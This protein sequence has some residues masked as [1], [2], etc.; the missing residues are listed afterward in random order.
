VMFPPALIRIRVVSPGEK[1]IALWL[2]IFLLWIP[3]LVV[4]VAATPLVLVLVLV[5]VLMPR[6]RRFLRQCFDVFRLLC[7]SRGTR[8]E[9]DDNEDNVFVD[10]R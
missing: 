8:I 3:A 6:V 10:I 2:P 7:C 1:K 5:G 4:A 9:V